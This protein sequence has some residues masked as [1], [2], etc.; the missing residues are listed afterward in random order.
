MKKILVLLLSLLCL[1]GCTKTPSEE[2]SVTTAPVDETTET[3]VPTTETTSL[4][5]E[6][7]YEYEV[8]DN[9]RKYKLFDGHIEVNVPEPTENTKLYIYNESTSDIEDSI[10]FLFA[11]QPD[12]CEKEEEGCYWELTQARFYK[13]DM[14]QPNDE[15]GFPMYSTDEEHKG[16]Q[17]YSCADPNDKFSALNVPEFSDESNME[18]YL[19]CSEEV[20]IKPVF[21]E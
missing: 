9:E 8:V 21:V 15:N 5:D 11:F 6:N 18:K 16:Y 3:T 7:G 17:A 2:A 13:G 19:Q 1:S 10:V 20:Y 12:G 14:V 4:T